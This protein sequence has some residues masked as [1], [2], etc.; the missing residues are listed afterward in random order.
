MKAKCDV[1]SVLGETNSG[2]STLV[3]AIVG[4]KVSIVS[5]KVQT[6][7]FNISGICTQGNVQLVLIDTPGF[8]RSKNAKNYEKTTW[9]AFRQSDSVLFVVDANKKHFG[10][11]QKLLSK[12]D[13]HKNV[14]LVLNKIDLLHKTDL[15]RITD[16][17]AKIR[18]Y[19]SVFMVSALNND[20][21]DKLRDYLMKRAPA[22]EWLFN[23]D[24]IT[25]QSTEKYVAEITREHIYDL[26][27]QE[28][29]YHS[30]V[31]TISI[32]QRKTGGWKITQEII[33]HKESHK[34]MVIGKN[35][36]KIKSIGESARMELQNILNC[37]VQLFLTVRVAGG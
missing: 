37:P 13:K 21:V 8:F 30:E 33:V 14:I 3:N 25:D 28:I 6:T 23:E 19:D 9:D 15:L 24:L 16:E 29:P 10:T 22:G 32:E 17:F 12:I 20:G 27:H 31:K 1:I 18:E 34:S 2:K 35:G 11:T 26:L 36:S 7:I 4:Q 5:R